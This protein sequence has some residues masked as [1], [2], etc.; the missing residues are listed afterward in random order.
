MEEI[1]AQLRDSS[2]SAFERETLEMRLQEIEEQLAE[3]DYLDT[4]L[5]V[6]GTDPSDAE[7]EVIE[8]RPRCLHLP[9]RLIDTRPQDPS[10]HQPLDVSSHYC[11]LCYSLRRPPPL[12]T[13]CSADLGADQGEGGTAR[14]SGC[15]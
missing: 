10:R 12:D 11:W 14:G 2:L 7:I 9:I 8:A 1:Q 6:A 5:Q 4:S 3:P 15:L 13:C